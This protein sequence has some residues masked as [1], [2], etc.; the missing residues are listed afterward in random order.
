MTGK[1]LT[2]DR[3]SD[4]RSD[5]LIPPPAVVWIMLL[6]GSADADL[7]AAY[8]HCVERLQSAVTTADG[9][10]PDRKRA[11]ERGALAELSIEDAAAVLAVGRSDL[12]AD[13]IHHELLDRILIGMS[14]AVLDVDSLARAVSIDRTGKELQQRIEGRA[15]MTVAEYVEIRHAIEARIP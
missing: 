4:G 3:L 14:T 12:T 7:D 5:T 1:R 2:V 15:P 9:I 6:D 11:I 10:D 13:A 8:A